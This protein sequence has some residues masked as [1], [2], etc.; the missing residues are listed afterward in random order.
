MH[1][2]F[3]NHGDEYAQPIRPLDPLSA[4]RAARRTRRRQRQEER[5]FR[6]A[7]NGDYRGA[8]GARA[9]LSHA[10][11]ASGITA[12]SRTTHPTAG[13]QMHPDDAGIHLR[14]SRMP[15]IVSFSNAQRRNS[16]G[17]RM[18]ELGVDHF[19][20]GAAN[21]R[22]YNAIVPSGTTGNYMA[23]D[24]NGD[25]HD[26]RRMRALGVGYTD[27]AKVH[28][29]HS[30]LMSEVG[31]E[32]VPSLNYPQPPHSKSTRKSRLKGSH[33]QNY[34]EFEHGF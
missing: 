25:L 14:G 21:G 3:T 28:R 34:N 7:T 1:R 8:V 2:G 23:N 20:G 22:G 33:W 12:S 30:D 24:N 5:A 9:R 4:D 19:G 32:I 26:Y 18:K 29:G 27:T 11:R 10:A 6:T 15:A 31:P 16:A 13:R 17:Y